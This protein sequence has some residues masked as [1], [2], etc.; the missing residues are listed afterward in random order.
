ME[1][2]KAPTR[3]EH[4]NTTY[5]NIGPGFCKPYQDKQSQHFSETYCN[6]VCARLTTLLRCNATCWVLKIELAHM[7]RHNIAAQTWLNDYNIMHRPQNFII[8]EKFDYFQIWVNNTQ[9]VKQCGQMHA[10]CCTQ[11][12]W[13]VLC[14]NVM[15]VWP[16]IK[17]SIW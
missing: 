15:I 14:W 6:N 5:C 11:Q 10:T 12:Y 17:I 8:H 16:G 2:F 7:L 4:C 3:S 1:T 9:N 13:D